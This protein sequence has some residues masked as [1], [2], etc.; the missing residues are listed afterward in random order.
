MIIRTKSTLLNLH[1]K[2]KIKKDIENW[3]ERAQG[4]F[5]CKETFSAKYIPW[6]FEDV[7]KEIDAI[8]AD[9]MFYAQ[10]ELLQ[11]LTAGVISL[12]DTYEIYAW[13]SNEKL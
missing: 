1:T 6:N 9:S 7:K 12:R 3:N 5:K 11:D 10:K 4:Y 2:E 8:S 13:W